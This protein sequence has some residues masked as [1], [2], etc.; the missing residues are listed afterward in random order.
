MN[1]SIKLYLPSTYNI[2]EEINQEDLKQIHQKVIKEI[3]EMFGGCT[4]YNATGGYLYN[5]EVIQENVQVLEAF[6]TRQG[7]RKHKNEVVE[8]A[9]RLKNILKQD[10]I[11]LQIN[12]NL[13]FI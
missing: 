6:T 8:I 9:K 7:I 5:N 2:D 11:A 4:L 10:S 1:K 3:S 13:Q 12:N